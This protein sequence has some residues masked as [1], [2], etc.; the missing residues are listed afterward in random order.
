LLRICKKEHK[1]KNSMQREER[2]W[3]TKSNG[4]L[5]ATGQFD[6]TKQNKIYGIRTQALAKTAPRLV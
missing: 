6:E 3:G 5:C 4:G 1:N 2:H